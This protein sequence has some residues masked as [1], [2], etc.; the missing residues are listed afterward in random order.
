MNRALLVGI[1]KYPDADHE[2][3]G[4][5]NDVNEMAQFLTNKCDFAHDDIRLL[6]DGRAS[7]AAI[8][9]RLH[10]LIDSAKS[11]DRLFFHYSGHG[12]QV[13]SRGAQA[14]V[15]HLEEVICPVDFDWTKEK[16][17]ITDREFNQLFSKVPD[18]VEFIWVSDSCHSGDLINDT[19]VQRKQKSKHKPKSIVP[20]ADHSWRLKTAAKKNIRALTMNKSVHGLNMVLISA[21]KP[22]QTT[23]DMKANGA[24]T[25]FLLKELKKSQGLEKDL[26]TLVRNINAALK[27]AKFA[28]QPQLEGSPLI[29]SKPF[30][31]K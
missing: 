10:W 19:V 18:G 15:D 5:I 20:P 17:M 9:E 7:T 31:K 16:N 22:D 2:L 13:A 6:T 27:K 29:M 26:T 4:C 14:E 12:T 11:G 21:C 24:L 1:N 3:H 23:V 25:Y 8:K 30:L 28:Q